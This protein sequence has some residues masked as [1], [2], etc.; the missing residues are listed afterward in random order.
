MDGAEG[1]CEFGT[2]ADCSL[3]VSPATSGSREVSYNHEVY[4]VESATAIV[5]V[6]AGGPA[7]Y[8][9]DSECSTVEMPGPPD[10]GTYT[11]NGVMS[12]YEGGIL[13]CGI[14]H[15]FKACKHWRPGEA[16]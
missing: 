7:W 1:K 3:I 11:Q 8:L 10:I 6:S 5:Q 9:Q 16:R 12:L 2:I 13:V 15:P 14:V 4:E